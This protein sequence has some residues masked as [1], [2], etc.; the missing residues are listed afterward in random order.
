M[1]IRCSNCDHPNEAGAVF[2]ARCN[3]YLAWSTA[4][5]RPTAPPPPAASAPTTRAPAPVA[6]PVTPVSRTPPHGESPS[7]SPLAAD[8]REMAA[9]IEQT[10][11]LAVERRR[12]DLVERLDA[13]QTKLRSRSV[14][15]AV[16]GEFKRGKS[17]LV[18]ALIQRSVC[19][20]DADIVTAVPTMVQYGEQPVVTAYEQRPDEE[21]PTAR[22]VR[23]EEVHALVSEGIDDP[24][25]GLRSV[26]VRVPH[27]MLRSGLRLLDTPGVGGLESVHGQLTLGSLG[28]VDGLLFVTDASQELT[29]PEMEFL[30]TALLRCDI[31]AVV[32]TKTDLHR[33]W[34]RIVDLDR[35]HLADAG[36]S[37]PV[38][39]VSSFLRLEAARRPALNDESGFAALVEFLARDVMQPATKRSIATAA[40]DVDFVADQLSRQSD[41]ERV[42]LARPERSAEV[43]EQL[44]A[45]SGRARALSTAGAGWQQLLSDGV[46]DLAADV[47]HDLQTRI[48]KVVKDV[49]GLI[50]QSD[51]RDT[52]PD[53]GMWLRRQ[54]AA[55][56]VANRDLLVRRATE[57]VEAVAAEFHLESGEAVDVRLDLVSR[58]LDELELPSASTF[59]P[60]GG[61]LGSLMVTARTTAIV[62]MV[63]FHL[64]TMASGV[65]ILAVVGG[66]AL[67][68]TGVGRKLYLDEGMRQL[69]YRQTQAKTAATKFVEEAAFEMSKSTRDSLRR[70]QRLLRDEFQARARMIQ[71]SADGALVAAQQA[72]TLDP[73]GQTRRSVQL[74]QEAARLVALRSDMRPLA[75][76][77]ATLG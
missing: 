11:H 33:S 4:P 16:V 40:R 56:G 8:L 24:A 64:A 25:A 36:L 66:A 62:P 26:E 58:S 54:T 63:A 72:R 55:A 41:A 50:D 44:S 43:V 69:S 19:P 46:Q 49:R 70:T 12:Q 21:Q 59:A 17:S 31:A 67:A 18:N 37:L 38:I 10:R 34:R 32:V 35:G 71:A 13:T 9:A 3:H 45:A 7:S 28:G 5:S 73:S 52:W 53:T 42:V 74:D 60:P 39:P 51:P 6:P 75:T 22:Q 15:V 68:T 61:R 76:A 29:A 27:R 77:G 65:W 20:V 1:S 47:E 30:R 23:A 57:L 14:T 2:C 48:R